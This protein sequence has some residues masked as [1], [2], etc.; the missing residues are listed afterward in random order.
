MAGIIIP[1]SR[2]KKVPCISISDE[3]MIHFGKEVIYNRFDQNRLFLGIKQ[4][5]SKTLSFDLGYMRIWQKK[6]T[7]GQFDRDHCLRL[8]FYYNR[9]LKNKLPAGNK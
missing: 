3:V 4:N 1:V 7:A 5:I 9:P 2:N 6:Y 8:F